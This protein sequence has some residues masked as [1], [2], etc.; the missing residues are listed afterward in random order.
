MSVCYD[1]S[2]VVIHHVADDQIRTGFCRVHVYVY[3]D[4]YMYQ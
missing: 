2:N 4:I 3:K 1:T